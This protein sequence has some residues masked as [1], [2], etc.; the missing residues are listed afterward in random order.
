MYRIS[1]P[2]R[3]D[4]LRRF[5]S[6]QA[7]RTANMAEVESA[8]MKPPARLDTYVY[9]CI[10][11][12]IYVYRHINYGNHRITCV[13]TNVTNNGNANNT[14]CYYYYY[15]FYYFIFTHSLTDH[16][17]VAMSHR[18][19]PYSGP[20][21][22]DEGASDSLFGAPEEAVSYISQADNEGAPNRAPLRTL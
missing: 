4:P 1:L 19:V 12:Y 8:N 20:P 7:R 21:A 17:R 3:C 9:V 16:R 11:I 10:Y 5:D 13:H 2:I 18:S 22:P 14:C 15:Y 6:S